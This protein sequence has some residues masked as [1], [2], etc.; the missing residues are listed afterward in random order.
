MPN[1]F[2][3]RFTVA[4]RGSRLFALISFAALLLASRGSAQVVSGG[5]FDIC[6]FCGSLV[7]NTAK[8]QGRPGFGTN[9][10]LFVLINAATD[11]QDVDRD[12]YTPGVNFTNLVVSDTS[13]F[14]N[15]ANP[16]RVIQ[17]R[18][19]VISD[20]L[21]P[22]NNG[23][24]NRVNFY[25]N[26]PEGTAAGTYRGNFIIRDAV[27]GL[28]QNPNGEALRIDFVTVEIEVLP[29]RELELVQ[30]DTSARL[31]SL[32]LR[33]RA[34]QTV[35]GVVRLANLGNLD[36]RD[37]RLEATDLIA[38][39]GTGLRIRRERISFTPTSLT[40]VGFGD[41]ARVVVT[42]RI[43]AGL[44]AG[45][46]RGELIAQAEGVDEIR[47]PFTVIVTTPGDIVFETNPVVGRAGDLA[48][49]IFNAD[50]G[51]QWELAIFDMIGITT[52]KTSGTVFEGRPAGGPG[53]VA[54]EGDRAVRYTWSLVNG[55]G[56]NV[57]GGMYYVVINAVQ[58]GEQRQLR[59]KLMVIR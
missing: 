3:R 10:G 40:N 34:G 1:H 6:D 51:T 26:V 58:D 44:L 21:N 32:V 17:K 12:G 24:Q 29:I 28:G 49:I 20:F 13:D 7:G 8:L 39:S 11:P 36:L 46:Y 35:S 59:S 15:V 22:L 18:N 23:F 9:N 41:T 45:S 4:R 14:I 19:L 48:V 54:F 42:V 27:L 25:V 43:P 31:D 37:A 16:S 30:A 33:G 56:E 2:T 38:T 50:P 55:R 53:E 52:F 5:D 57:A 47:V